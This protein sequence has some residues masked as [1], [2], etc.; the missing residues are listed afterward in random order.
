MRANCRSFIMGIFASFLCGM[1]I[2]MVLGQAGEALYEQKCGRCHDLIEPGAYGADEWP[3]QVRAMKAHANLTE[4]Q[5]AAIVEYLVSTCKQSNTS[6]P[7]NNVLGGYLYTEYFKTQEKDLNFDLHY[8][9]LSV[10]GWAND[11]INYFAEFELEHGG[12]GDN[13]FVE[14]AYIDFWLSPFVALKAGAM[15]TPF[16]RFDE[17]HGPLKNYTITR[18][19]MS[20]EIGVSAW[21]DIGI[22]FHGYIPFDERYSLSFNLYTING[23][24]GG[25]DLR[26]SRQ[27]QDNNENLSF[28]GRLNLVFQDAFEIG[29]SGYRGAWDSDG[30]Y[31]LSMFGAH[32]L[33]K[34]SL[35]D[36]YGEL[37]MATSENPPGVADGDI[38]GFFMQ[39]SKLINKI[40]R[41]TIR[42]G[43]LDYLDP[44][45]ALGRSPSKGNK[46]LSELVFSLGYYPASWTVI[47][48]E[49][50]ILMEGDRVSSKDNNQFGLQF[51]LQF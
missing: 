51:A 41:P 38:S 39:A 11:R 25:S 28:G 40:V 31:N 8:L 18:P 32:L 17:F 34:T 35:A 36:I 43:S 2:D 27:Y 23:L 46:D 4:S 5:Y 16:N 26:G 33:W 44:G 30:E 7:G 22:D 1:P 21:K 15:L 6:L 45:A 9:S 49:Y 10:S 3:G 48:A 20:R 50:Q 37:A 29:G 13:T 14:Q 47:K 24:G 12:K 19:Q 42:Y